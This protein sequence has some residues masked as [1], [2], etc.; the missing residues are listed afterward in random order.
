[1]ACGYC[2]QG[3]PLEGADH[4]PARGWA[5]FW[6]GRVCPVCVAALDTLPNGLA[7]V[8]LVD[9]LIVADDAAAWDV[10]DFVTR[11]SAVW[12][13]TPYD[14]G[15][16]DRWAH[17]DRDRLAAVIGAAHDRLVPQ[18]TPSGHGCPACGASRAMSWPVSMNTLQSGVRL[19]GDCAPDGVVGDRW[20]DELVARLAGVDPRIE[21]NFTAGLAD[22]VG[23]RLYSEAHPGGAGT[24]V[25]WG[26]L[27]D[28]AVEDLRVWAAGRWTP[29]A[30]PQ[31]SAPSWFRG[32]R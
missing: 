5:E 21:G 17:V 9:D 22:R 31:P 24:D 30:L 13:T 32:G 10:A 8:R 2:G 28:G 27:G 23:F 26:Y 11:Y 12:G 15:N 4:R 7:P 25:P 19:C 1:L 20:R 29:R 14:G 16:A 3:T 6:D 18:P